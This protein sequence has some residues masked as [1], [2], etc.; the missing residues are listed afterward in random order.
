MK[1]IIMLLSVVI[2]T[3]TA[4][5]QYWHQVKSEA[6][7]LKGTQAQIRHIIEIPGKGIISLD[8]DKDI[9]SFT[10][11]DGIFSYESP[12][13]YLNVVEGIFGWYGEDG[14]LLGKEN[15][16][17]NV[18]VENPEFAVADAT[19]SFPGS[20]GAGLKKIAFWIRYYKG[21]VRIIIPRYGKTDFDVTLPTFLSQI[22][23]SNEQS[24][25]KGTPQKK[26]TKKPIRRK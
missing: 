9:F 19:R 16:L 7:E 8:D 12:R 13:K 3:L 20:N 23:P 25:P 18:N 24:K 1:K 6:D 2:T 4:S 26:S 11:Y 14:E 10:T 22:K 15:I 5:A 17:L 21:S